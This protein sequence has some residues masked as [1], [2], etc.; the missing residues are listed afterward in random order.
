MFQNRKHAGELLAKALDLY[1]GKEDV[2]VIGIPRG[3]MVPAFEVAKFLRAPLD[4]LL[5]KKI[6]HPLNA[7]YAIGA[8]SMDDIIL[9]ANENISNDY[10]MEE[11]K[12]VRHKMKEQDLAFKAGRPIIDLN[13]KTVILVDDGVATGMTIFMVIELVKKAGAKSIIVAIPVCPRDTLE[14]LTEKV[15]RV[16]CLEAPLHFNAVGKHYE[17]FEQVEDDEVLALFQKPTF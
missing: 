5:V 10:I 15:D 14:Q 17:E 4:L 12:R 2:V 8:A 6:G 3:G 16:I 13:N 1:L 9:L 7:E 11:V